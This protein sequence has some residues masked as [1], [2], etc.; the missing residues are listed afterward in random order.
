MNKQTIVI[1][2]SAHLSLRRGQLVIYL[3]NLAQEEERP[4][5]DLAFLLLEHREITLTHPLL[6]ALADANV[7]LLCTNETHLP[8]GLLLSL[9]HHY[10]Q[11]ERLEAQLSASAPL[12]KQLWKR[13]VQAKIAQQAR[14]L[15]L[16]KHTEEATQLRMMEKEVQSGDRSHL[17]AQAARIYWGTLFGPSFTRH[18]HGGNPNGA[19]NYGYAI[20]RAATARALALHGLFVMIGIHHHNRYNAFALADDFMEPYRPFVDWSVLHLAS[21]LSSSLEKEDKVALLRMLTMDCY[22]DGK[23]TT[24]GKALEYTAAGLVNALEKKDPSSLYFV[25]LHES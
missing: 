9:D 23:R 11:R 21:P 16:L 24:L 10:I 13:V 8:N 4:I 15:K 7:A 18:R 14:L 3:R 19:L 12:K 22:N 2:Q 1:T 25:K 5:E 6:S 17:E 20:L